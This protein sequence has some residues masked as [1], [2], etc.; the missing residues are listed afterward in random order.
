MNSSIDPTVQQAR[1][2]LTVELVDFFSAHGFNAF[3]MES[4][5]GEPGVEVHTYRGPSDDVKAYVAWYPGHAAIDR[6]AAEIRSG[7]FGPSAQT[8]VELSSANQTA[9]LAQ[10]LTAAG[11]LVV[12][13]AFDGSDLTLVVRPGTKHRLRQRTSSPGE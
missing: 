1:H 10:A 9:A 7:R 8:D 5:T 2:E 11:Y 12:S 3:T 6:Q 13:V 4:A